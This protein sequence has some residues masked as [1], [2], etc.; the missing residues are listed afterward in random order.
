MTLRTPALACD[1][2]NDGVPLRVAEIS[3]LPPGVQADI[4]KLA[5][6]EY[7]RNKADAAELASQ[8]AALYLSARDK[9]VLIIFNPGGWGWATVEQMPLWASILK[10]MKETLSGLGQRVM[11]VNYIRTPH[12]AGGALSE[13]LALAN[14]SRSKGRELAARVDFLTRHLPGL[15]VIIAGESNGAARAEDAMDFLRDNPRVFSVQTGTPF[16]APS[17]PFER[18][19]IINHNGAEADSFSNGDVRRWFIANVQ[20]LFGRYKGSRGN[21]LLYIG[22]PG[23]VYNWDYPAVREKIIRFLTG[24]VVTSKQY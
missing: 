20:A 7:G 6:R 22:A 15:K 10:G 18:S 13:W 9:N 21:V 3:C 24:T 23:H 2:E 14:L 19:L 12:S 5:E 8:I 17:K 16:W 1:A 11:V 4:L